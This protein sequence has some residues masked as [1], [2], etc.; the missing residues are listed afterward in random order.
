LLGWC[1]ELLENNV[2]HRGGASV[3]GDGSFRIAG[4]TDALLRRLADALL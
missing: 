2:L 1:T 3:R 4:A